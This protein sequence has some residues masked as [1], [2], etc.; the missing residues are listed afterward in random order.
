VR[1]PL[2]V[3][4]GNPLDPKVEAHFDRANQLLE[5]CRQAGFPEEKAVTILQDRL[6]RGI[7]I[8]DSVFNTRML[9]DAVKCIMAGEAMAYL[10]KDRDEV[11]L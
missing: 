1:H 9:L 7:Q 3:N 2:A 11:P 8:V 5:R 10:G 4:T 6:D